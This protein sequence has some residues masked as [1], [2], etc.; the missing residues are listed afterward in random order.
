MRSFF[1]A[2]R[3]A[4]RYRF[5]LAA[6]ML[7]SLAIG[8]LWG[9]NIGALYPFVEIVFRGE[10]LQESY[11]KKIA[12]ANDNCQALSATIEQLERQLAAAAGDQ[13]KKLQVEIADQRAR[14]AAEHHALKIA[15]RYKPYLDRYCPRDPFLTLVVVIAALILGTILKNAFLVAN[16]VLIARVVQLTLVDLQNEFFRRTLR[17]DLTAFHQQATSNIVGRFVNEMR[18]IAGSLEAFFGA[19]VRE[20]LKMAACLFG[21]AMISWRLLLLSMICAPVGILMLR[22]LSQ[23]IKRVTQHS[24]NLLSEQIRRLTESYGGFVTV[25]AF[26]LEGRERSRFRYVTKEIASIAQKISLLFSLSKP[27]AETM[28]VGVTS[29]AILAGAYLVLNRETHLLGI[30]ITERPLEPAA[31]MVFFG[32]LAGIA[33][34]ARK[35]SGIFGQIYTGVI[36]AQGVYGMMDRPV[37]I[38][39][40][41]NAISFKRL[42]EQMA[43]EGLQFAYQPGEPVLQDINLSIGANEK[44]ALVGPN[45]CGKSTLVKLLL[46]F[47]DP[48]AGRIR[49]DGR[50]LQEYRIRDVRRQIGIVTQETWLFD[51][52]IAYNIR[53]GKPGATDEEVMQAARKAHAHR[54]ISQELP[55]GYETKV[56]E[57]GSR[58]SGGQRQRIALARVILRNPSILILDEATSEIDLESEQLIHASLAEFMQGRTTIMI[59]HRLSALALADRIVLFQRG[60]ILDVGSGAELESRSEVYN[61]LLASQTQ[62][63]A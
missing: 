54:F 30:Q 5:T 15:R 4:L 50:D 19:A 29:I 13:K 57:S 40:M 10:S 34:P 45:G 1:R 58:L 55:Q 36:A 20:P 14:V 7:C 38:K 60:R 6:A 12:V 11:E 49:L 16:V 46:R 44:I 43:L 52:T 32:L 22:L 17:Q 35:L 62:A 28:A 37:T 56:G 51:D 21:A 2:V 39:Q 23:T 18:M 3:A 61:R 33:D 24:L 9:A 31:L 53:C 25:K 41:P 47:Y 48:T 59:S 42:K 8:T 27:I 26:T 63:A